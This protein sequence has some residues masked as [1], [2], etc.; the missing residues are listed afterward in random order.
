MEEGSIGCHLWRS[1]FITGPD[2]ANPSHYK[3]GCN[4]LSTTQPNISSYITTTY[5]AYYLKNDLYGEESGE[6][7]ISIAQD[8]E[9]EQ[10]N[11]RIMLSV[12]YAII[13]NYE[14]T[15]TEHLGKQ[16]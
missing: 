1:K 6:D 3:P 14:K 10:G 9:T 13:V 15:V 2:S 16:N 5:H 11:R 8:L 7:M 4:K 12:V